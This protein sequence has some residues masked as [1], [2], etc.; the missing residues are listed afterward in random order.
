[1]SDASNIRWGDVRPTMLKRLA[2]LKDS[3]I[4][5]QPGEVAVLQGQARALTDLIEWFERGAIAD[6]QLSET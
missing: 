2:A 3:L 6:Q 1:M 5:A 4:Y